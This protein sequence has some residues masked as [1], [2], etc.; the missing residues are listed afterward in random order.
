MPR[1]Y[2]LTKPRLAQLAERLTATQSN[3]YTVC[4]AM[5]GI[6][7]TDEV[8]D[9]LRDECGIR[10]CSECGYWLESPEF[11]DDVVTTCDACLNEMD[12]D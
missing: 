4:K 11:Y 3:V 2:K 5:F 8:F 12:G 7:A 10:K 6:E 9:R 1:A